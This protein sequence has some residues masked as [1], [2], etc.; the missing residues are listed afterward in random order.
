[1]F[2]NPI[3][4][5]QGRLSPPEKGRF[6]SFPRGH[7]EK[8]F[9]LA[10]ELGLDY[11]EWIFDSHGCNPIEHAD[12]VHLVNQLQKQSRVRVGALCGDWF[13][14]K[15]LIRCTAMQ[16]AYRRGAL[17]WLISRAASIGASRVILPFVDNASL[18]SEEEKTIVIDIL[19]KTF[20]F[21][22]AYKV[23]LYVEM[24]LPP[25]EFADFLSR[26]PGIKVNYDI[27]NSSGLGYR[28]SEEFSVYGDRIGAVHVKDRY[29][30]PGGGIE[31]RPL[32]EGSAD[33]DDVWAALKSIDYQG[34]FTL[35]VARGE[36]GKEFEFIQRQIEF[37]RKVWQ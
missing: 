20:H 26:T 35:Q 31:T 5:M 19:N 21:A 32:G 34:G 17:Y 12:G 37:L 10:A 9:V 6:Q 8:E 13:M 1:M 22:R 11:I 2:S 16:R 18:T 36:S 28:A 14:E 27:G 3:G 30:K 4:I 24:D 23:E 7:W 15:P 33:F 25:Q 29:R